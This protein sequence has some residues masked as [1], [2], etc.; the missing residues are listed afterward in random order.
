V[1]SPHPEGSGG[2]PPDLA[3]RLEALLPGAVTA[4]GSPAIYVLASTDGIRDRFIEVRHR[5][6][7]LGLLPLLRARHGQP[8]LIITPQPPPGRWAWQLNALL[9]VATIGTTFLTGY[10]LAAGLARAGLL[11]NPI[12]T[13]VLY[14]ASVLFILGAH[15]MGHKLVAVRRG[16]DASL[17]YFI[18]MVPVPPLPGTLGAVIVTRTPAPNRDS[19]MDLGAS[20]PIAG[21]LAAIPVIVY[22]VTHSFVV[23]PDQIGPSYAVPDPLFIQW[24]VARLLDPPPGSVVFGHPLLFAGWI[25][26]VVTSINLLP[27]GM[28]DGGHA[29]RAALGARAHRFASF[30]GLALAVGMGYYAMAVLIALLMN[31]PHVGPLDDLSPMSPSRR[32]TGLAL[33]VIF[34]LS[35]VVMRQPIL[36]R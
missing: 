9:L 26:L 20:G 25:G 23:R 13:G 15:E 28:L 18:P 36:D 30:A 34:V 22:G 21:F 6:A 7:P 14:S 4:E 12:L 29:V 3:E 35:V 31:R 24:L 27:A 11:H 19:L 33:I 1:K 32:L 10:Q 17:P 2:G 5:L 8:V 16:I